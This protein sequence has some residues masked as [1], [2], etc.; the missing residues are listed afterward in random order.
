MRGTRFS[1]PTVRRFPRFR[2]AG[3]TLLIE[4]RGDQPKLGCQVSRLY[5]SILLGILTS[6]RE[7][8]FFDKNSWIEA[9]FDKK[10]SLFAT[11]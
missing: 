7:K 9:F 6:A 3:S 10:Q 5:R 8:S 11:R 2:S 1:L 4:L